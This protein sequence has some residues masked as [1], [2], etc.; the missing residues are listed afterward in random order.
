[1]VCSSLPIPLSSQNSLLTAAFTSPWSKGFF[2]HKLHF[3]ITQH[4]LSLQQMCRRHKI[5]IRRKL[6]EWHP[7]SL[8]YFRVLASFLCLDSDRKWCGDTNQ[9]TL[10]HLQWAMSNRW[11][12]EIPM[13]TCTEFCESEEYKIVTVNITQWEI[14]TRYAK[15]PAFRTW[16]IRGGSAMRVFAPAL[17]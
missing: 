15:I 11:P 4:N 12:T 7:L 6:G 5:W 2:C 10:K 1:M 14:H 16:R 8:A 9:K 3:L 13:C 17:H